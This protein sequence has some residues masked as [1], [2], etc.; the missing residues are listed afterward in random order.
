MSF[1]FCHIS[2]HQQREYAHDQIIGICRDI[3][4]GNISSDEPCNANDHGDDKNKG[5]HRISL[6]FGV[7]PDE[8]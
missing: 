6:F 8:L 4:N 3:R 5:L 7:I 1:A 2:E